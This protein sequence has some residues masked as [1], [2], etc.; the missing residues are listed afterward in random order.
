MRPQRIAPIVLVSALLMTVA[1]A[2]SGATPTVPTSSEGVSPATTSTSSIPTIGATSTGETTTS[3]STP[4]ATTTPSPP[5]PPTTPSASC[6][7]T[8]VKGLTPDERA[9]QLLMVGLDVNAGHSSLDQLVRS[10]HLGGVI[11]LGGWYDGAAA[12]RATTSH[13]AGLASKQ[14]T[15]GLGLFL[16]A[17][18]EGGN[19][20]QLRGAGFTRIGT[21]RAQDRLSPS[22]L[23]NASA[24]W[25]TQ[26][27]NAGIN[28]NLAPVADTV[29]TS[30]GRANQPI[31]RWDRQFSS[32]PDRVAQMVGGFIAG[33][34]RGE[35]AATIKHFP[36]LGRITGNTDTTA[37]GITDRTTTTTDPYLRPFAAGIKDGADL[38]MVGSAIYAKIDPGTNAVFSRRVVTDLLRGRLGYTGVVITDDVGAAKS[39][40]AVPVDERA[41]RFIAAGGDIVLTAVPATIAPMHEAITARMASDTAFAKQVDASVARVVALKVSRGLTHC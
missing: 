29:P 13:L 34:H 41:T 39:V 12:V 30:I 10:R 28:V 32:D 35:V 14:D 2:C 37:T 25:A 31:G 11:L 21:A 8:I 5:A 36:G 16:A 33:M 17:D 40:A 18:Q 1:A 7:A 26:M 24:T 9:G 19:V 4:A 15:G 38:V 3:S 6:A 22:Q 27:K 23:A 20:Q